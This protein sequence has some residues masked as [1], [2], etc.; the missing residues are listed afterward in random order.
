VFKN[1][2]LIL[3]YFSCLKQFDLLQFHYATGISPKF[4]GRVAKEE[5]VAAAT[6]SFKITS[7]PHPIKTV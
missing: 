2:N 1:L 7:S 4:I 6:T 5:I 3:F